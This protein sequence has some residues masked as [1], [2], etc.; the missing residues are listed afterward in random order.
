MRSLGWAQ[1]KYDWCP[2]EKKKFKHTH[3]HTGGHVNIQNKC[4]HLQ[5]KER[6]LR[7]KQIVN[8]L[9]LDFQPTEL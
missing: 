8:S 7:R 6:D 5:A 2:Y 4:G 3:T 1:I 9:I